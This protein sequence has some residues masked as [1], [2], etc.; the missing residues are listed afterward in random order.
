MNNALYNQIFEPGQV[1]LTLLGFFY[2]LLFSATASIVSDPN[3][4]ASIACQDQA[5]T[6]EPV[7]C[8]PY[9]KINF[10]NMACFEAQDFHSNVALNS[11]LFLK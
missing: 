5:F 9:V 10:T 8:F 3:L 7:K 2:Q 1:T 4:S 6:F 11:V